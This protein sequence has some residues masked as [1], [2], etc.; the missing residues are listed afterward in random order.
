MKT[1]FSSFCFRLAPIQ[2]QEEGDGDS[3]TKRGGE[4]V[5]PRSIMA[6]MDRICGKPLD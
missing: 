3:P 2:V 5:V 1:N 4:A 6:M